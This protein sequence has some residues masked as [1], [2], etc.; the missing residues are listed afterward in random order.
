VKRATRQLK[1]ES[2]IGSEVMTLKEA[3]DYL[4]C[5]YTTVYRLVRQRGLPVF[6]LGS[7]FRVLRGDLDKWI[8]QRQVRPGRP[9]D[10]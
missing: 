9:G 2:G 7:D 3:A 4:K 10:E 8:A 5:H 6:R 1:S